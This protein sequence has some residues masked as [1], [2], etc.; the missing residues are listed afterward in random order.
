MIMLLQWLARIGVS[1][2][3][4]EGGSGGGSITAAGATAGGGAVPVVSTSTK[5]SLV[6]MPL[7]RLARIDAS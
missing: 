3:L 1:S 7:Q 6:I 5:E 4:Q 2:G